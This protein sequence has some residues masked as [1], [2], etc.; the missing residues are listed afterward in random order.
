[1]SKPNLETIISDLQALGPMEI[2]SEYAKILAERNELKTE[3]ETLRA[4]NQTLKSSSQFEF[5]DLKADHKAI[6]H[7]NQTHREKYLEL[8]ET[9]RKLNNKLGESKARITILETENKELTEKYS[10][11]Y[12][13]NEKFALE[14]EV[15]SKQLETFRAIQKLILNQG[16][17]NDTS[18]QTKSPNKK[19]EQEN[20]TF[21]IK[22]ENTTVNIKQEI[23]AMPN[24]PISTS[25]TSTQRNK[26]LVFKC[27]IRFPV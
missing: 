13:K 8:K 2:A 18:D 19:I 22:Q 7:E 9:T 12:K 27:E 26:A 11:I 5:D 21:N 17:L 1:M 24:I 15:Q 20:T 16:K 14:Y 4:E 23:I 10:R 25:S 3:I 6:L